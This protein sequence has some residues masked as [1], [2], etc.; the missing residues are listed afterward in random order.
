M[1]GYEVCMAMCF[2]HEL[3]RETVRPRVLQI[4][5]NV[6]LRIDD[7]G[8]GSRP[9]QVGGVSKTAEIELPKVHSTI[10]AYGCRVS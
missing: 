10:V 7:G 5:I 4:N 8:F 1:A 6:S 9:D 3:D 2:D